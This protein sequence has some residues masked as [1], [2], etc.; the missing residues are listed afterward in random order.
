MNDEFFERMGELVN[1]GNRVA[2][3]AYSLYAQEVDLVLKTQSRDRI[4]I[5]HLLDGILSFC[6]DTE[7][8]ALY[9]KLCHY[10]YKLDSDAT[11]SYVNAYREMWDD[12][13]EE[14]Q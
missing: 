1:E 7:I 4:H 5:E 6:F 2:R 14:S 9:K 12:D 11:A 13:T 8:L 3:Q 10:Y